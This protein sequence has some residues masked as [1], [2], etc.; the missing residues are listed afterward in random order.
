MPINVSTPTAPGVTYIVTGGGGAPLY[1]AGTS[2][3]T[4]YSSSRYEYLRGSADSCTLEI[5]AVGRDASVF[6]SVALTRCGGRPTRN[7]QQRR[8]PRPLR[9]R[10]SAE[11]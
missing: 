3:W 9:V 1:P 2:T 8:S 4:A 6:D 11:L 5:E 7:H 10:P